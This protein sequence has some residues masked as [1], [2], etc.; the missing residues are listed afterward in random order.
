M[1]QQ[2]STCQQIPLYAGNI[3]LKIVAVDCLKQQ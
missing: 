3:T 1:M 2:A